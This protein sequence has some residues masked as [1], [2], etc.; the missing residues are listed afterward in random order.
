M[1]TI[2]HVGILKNTGAKVLVVFRTLPGESDQALVIPTANL[3]EQFHNSLMTLVESDQAQQTNEFGEIMFIRK[4][5][6][7]RSMLQAMDQDGRMVKTP[8]DNILM[9]PTPGS[10]IPLNELNAIIAE[11]KNMAIDDLSTLVTGS[12]PKPPSETTVTETAQPAVEA[13][14]TPAVSNEPLSDKDIARS[15]RSQADSLYKEAA[16]LRKQADELDPPQKKVKEKAEAS[17]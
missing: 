8:T 11:Q 9:T 7:G 10:S 13:A 15:Y 17:A 1:K 5:P 6:D 4:F 12:R 14:P 2:K 3:P 16:K